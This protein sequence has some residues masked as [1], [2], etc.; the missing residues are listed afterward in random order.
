VSAATAQLSKK[1]LA[2]IMK[3]LLAALHHEGRYKVPIPELLSHGDQDRLGNIRKV[4]PR[5]RQRDPQ[6]EFVA[7]SD[8][9]HCSNIDNPAFFNSVVL[10]WLGR[11]FG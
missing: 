9:S 5:W 3:S 6:R 10:E 7:I 1:E 4:M 2:R 8:A 11:V